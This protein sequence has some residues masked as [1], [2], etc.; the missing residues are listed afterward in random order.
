MRE[1]TP[2]IAIPLSLL[3]PQQKTNPC[4]PHLH[5]RLRTS[6]A[7]LHVPRISSPLST[8]QDPATNR[9]SIVAESPTHHSKIQV[10]I[11]LSP[12]LSMGFCLKTEPF[13]LHSQISHFFLFFFS[14]FLTNRENPQL[15]CSLF[16][17]E[18]I[19]DLQSKH[20]HSTF[21]K[22]RR[23]FSKSFAVETIFDL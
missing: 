6:T 21:S 4:T 20:T 13:L 8:L 7:G 9:A 19:F 11:S 23:I 2:F 12:C 22:S 14:V 16:A 15:F 3:F 17:V 18:T 1:N 10:R 5:R